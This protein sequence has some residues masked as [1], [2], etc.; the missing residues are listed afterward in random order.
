MASSLKSTRRNDDLQ[1]L[2]N[3]LFIVAPSPAKPRKTLIAKLYS[4]AEPLNAFQRVKPQLTSR[5]APSHSRSRAKGKVRNEKDELRKKIDSQEA[6]LE[7]TTTQLQK[8]RLELDVFKD[9]ISSRPKID[10]DVELSNLRSKVT[11]L[12]KRLQAE[13]VVTSQRKY[14]HSDLYSAAPEMFSGTIT[15]K[16]AATKPIHNKP[17]RK[18][19]FG[20]VSA[21]SRTKRGLYPH[22]EKNTG[23]PDRPVPRKRPA[24]VVHPLRGRPVYDIDNFSAVDTVVSMQSTSEE[25]ERPARKRPLSPD[26]RRTLRNFDRMMG[27]PKNPIPCLVNRQ[28]GYRDGTRVSIL[29]PLSRQSKPY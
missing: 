18:Q 4:S 29:Q 17:S 8:V 22:R 2:E 12:G 27:I 9:K 21:N 11:A 5:P 1:Y 7:C 6:L 10:Q 19:N 16:A 20:H 14:V 3:H 26:N 23:Q 25:G 13:E 24:V 28:L 15:P